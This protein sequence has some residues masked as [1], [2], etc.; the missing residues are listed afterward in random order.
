MLL[1]KS[2]QLNEPIDL[3]VLMSY[4]LTPVPHSLATP[5]GFFNKTNKAALLHYIGEGATDHVVYPT[6]KTLYIRTV[7]P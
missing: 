7:A 2:Q 4:P 5:D 6:D 1:I 3:D